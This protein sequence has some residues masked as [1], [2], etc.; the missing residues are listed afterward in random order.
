MV[1]FDLNYGMIAEHPV[2]QLH[3]EYFWIMYSFIGVLGSLFL[4]K[5]INYVPFLRR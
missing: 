1:L 5:I 4:G 3:N 2:V